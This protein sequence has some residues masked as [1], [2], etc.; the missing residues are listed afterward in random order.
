MRC[1]F[2]MNFRLVILHRF[3]IEQITT[4][5]IT[6]LGSCALGLLS[7]LGCVEEGRRVRS[8]SHYI[9]ID[10][11]SVLSHL[12]WFSV[13][14]GIKWISAHHIRSARLLLWGLLDY[15]LRSGCL[16]TE[17]IPICTTIYCRL[18][19][20]WLLLLLSSTA[21]VHAS[22]HILLCLWLSLLLG[23]WLL[24][25]AERCTTLLYLLRLWLYLWLLR[26]GLGHC[27][28]TEHTIILVLSWW[29]LLS[30]RTVLHE[31]KATTLGL[32]L[33]T[34]GPNA[35][36]IRQIL[37]LRRLS[38]WLRL[39]CGC[40][41]LRLLDGGCSWWLLSCVG[42]DLPIRL[43]YIG[44]LILFPLTSLPSTSLSFFIFI[45]TLIVI[46]RTVIFFRIRA[47]ITI[48]RLW[49]I[50]V[51]FLPFFVLFPT[52]RFFL[53]FLW[54]IFLVIASTGCSWRRIAWLLRI[55]N[56]E[57]IGRRGRLTFSIGVIR[58]IELIFLVV[59]KPGNVFAAEPDILVCTAGRA[60]C[61]RIR[62]AAS[63]KLRRA[64]ARRRSARSTESTA[65]HWSMVMK[66]AVA[67]TLRRALQFFT[68]LTGEFTLVL[69]H[70][71]VA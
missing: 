6:W 42:F 28:T 25:K 63:T 14:E 2:L 29:W 48:I 51:I 68:G 20:S 50:G 31:G 7:R 23:W 18:C 41:R 71:R 5:G 52:L 8:W 64:H 36:Q 55:G 32:G 43:R 21:K 54:F 66:L 53:I 30:I 17:W 9:R 39:H 15:W 27:H 60:C 19:G 49:I 62:P 37:L 47:I 45:T 61:R 16:S 57:C 69:E 4:E 38:H 10:S 26:L 33:R 22:E 3:E 56:L 24:D 65:T 59:A 67:A 1:L 44:K 35:K 13:S 40:H 12:L 11:S 58:R 46:I 34:C 70:C